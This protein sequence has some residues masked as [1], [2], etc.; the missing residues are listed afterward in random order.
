MYTARISSQGPQGKSTLQEALRVTQSRQNVVRRY[1]RRRGVERVEF[2]RLPFHHRTPLHGGTKRGAISKSA[3]LS[4]LHC[5][6]DHPAVHY[7][8]R[9]GASLRAGRVR[10]SAQVRALRCGLDFSLASL[11]AFPATSPKP[12]GSLPDAACPLDRWSKCGWAPSSPRWSRAGSTKNETSLAGEMKLMPWPLR[13]LRTIATAC[14]L[15]MILLN[16]SASAHLPADSSAHFPFAYVQFGCAPTDGPALDFYFTAT[17]SECGKIVEPYLKIMIW[18]NLPQSAPYTVGS[19][20]GSG[21]RDSLPE[22]RRVRGRGFRQP[23]SRQIRQRKDFRRRIRNSLPRR[24]RG[25]RQLRRHV[26]PHPCVCG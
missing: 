4:L 11:P 15:G 1:R 3:A 2:L 25:K 24:Q 21:G 18:E 26:V 6:V 12:R 9:G 10:V 22:A 20:R 13:M 7:V 14:L 23:A 8:D 19:A 16:G 17:K 5:A